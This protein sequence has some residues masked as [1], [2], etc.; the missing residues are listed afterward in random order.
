MI[1]RLAKLLTNRIAIFTIITLAAILSSIVLVLYLNYLSIYFYF[2]FILLSSIATLEILSRNTYP[3]YK[4]A[5][6]LVVA[7]L[8]GFGLVFY[9][10]LGRKNITENKREKY[11]ST[12]KNTHMYLSINENIAKDQIVQKC[13]KIIYS[14]CKMPAFCAKSINYYSSGEKFYSEL[15]KSLSTAK[16]YIFLEY[17][18]I[19]PG[20]IWNKILEILK[21]KALS[22]V[23]VKIIYDDFG[24][25]LHL[26]R[27]YPTELKKYKIKV[28]RFN[29]IVPLLDARMNI[30]NHRKNAVIDGKTAFISGANI[31]DEYANISSYS[32]HWKDYGAKITG[33]AVNSFV[34]S[35]LDTW[36]KKHKLTNIEN[37]LNRSKTVSTNIVIPFQDSPLF[38]NSIYEDVLLNLIYSA[39]Y[40]I[41]IATPYLVPTSELQSAL[42]SAA[43]RGVKTEICI[44]G[45]PDKKSIYKISKVY[46]FCF[47]ENNISI[48]IYLPGFLHSKLATFDNT[49]AIIGTSNLDLRSVHS[50]YEIN[51]FAK[52]E[53]LLSELTRDINS[54]ISKSKLLNLPKRPNFFVR[55]YSAFIKIFAPLM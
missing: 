36:Q 53:K 27:N 51:M 3:E 14:Q 30:R 28:M 13:E 54:I 9:A 45:I 1:R 21:Q 49:Y 8:P 43:R 55:I 24:S 29:S 19:K 6:V 4:I 18:I 11:N 44:P 48:H 17:F 50:N 2:S 37:Y 15:I 32:K 5:W 42:L 10:F 22:G 35:F 16:C 41:Q 20:K 34:I 12:I 7:L 25:V 31:A 40:K 38:K 26:P 52:S 46:A 23:D 39:K 33:S 47:T